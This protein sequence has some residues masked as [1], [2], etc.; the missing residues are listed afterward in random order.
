MSLDPK[1][2]GERIRLARERQGISQ[3]ELADFIEKDQRAVSDYELGKR[4]IAVTDLP[5]LAHALRV[6]I[7]YFFEGELDT[8]DMER[9]LLEEF[10]Q[11]STLESKQ[12]VVEVV[13]TFLTLETHLR[14][15]Q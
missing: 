1:V 14:N 15:D 12:A 5:G 3:E 6:P 13:R 2:L 9:A 8:K 4:R 10:Q 7:L 11:L